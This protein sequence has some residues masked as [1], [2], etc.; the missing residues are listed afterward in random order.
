MTEANEE[1]IAA[2]QKRIR[3]AGT[4]ARLLRLGLLSSILLLAGVW[5]A[6]AI[7]SS[8]GAQPRVVSQTEETTSV[9][10]PIQG[11]DW[12]YV[13]PFLIAFAGAAGCLVALPA[14]WFFRRA[15]YAAL[16][17]RLAAVSDHERA[18]VLLPLRA[19]RLGD[20]RKLVTPL[21]R[22]LRVPTEV[23]PANPPTGRGDEPTP[24]ST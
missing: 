13:A 3:R 10:V 17:H 16:R 24:G 21:L 7:V 23:A 8:S 5:I 14:A 1:Q 6:G 9:A 19:E 15:C 18:A 2:L 20:T 4:L 22:A 11:A 12:L